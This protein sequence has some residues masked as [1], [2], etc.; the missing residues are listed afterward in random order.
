MEYSTMVDPRVPQRSNQDLSARL[1]RLPVVSSHI[2]WALVLAANLMI[3]YY[4]NAIFAY[5]TPAIKNH[6]D[7]SLGQIGFVNSAFF[8]GM[9]VGA[10]IGG[11][12]ADQLGR[13]PVLMWAT[14]IYSLGAIGTALSQNFEVMLITRVITGIGVQAATSVLLVYVA[15]MFPGR[16]R[17]RFLSVV[18]GGLMF[19]A[20]GAA[21]LAM[22]VLPHGGPNAWR[23]LFMA[24]GVGILIVP[25]IYF[26]LPESVRWYVSVGQ[27]EKAR[28][29]VEKLEAKALRKGPLSEPKPV[30]D[31]SSE[32]PSL[33][34]LITDKSILRVVSIISI[35]FFGAT[36]GYYLFANWALYSLV[37]GLHYSEEK[38]YGIQ[39]IWNVVY[40]VTPFV[41]FFIM[42]LFERKNLMFITAVISA[43][44]LVFLGTSPD[45]WMVIVSGGAAAI[46]TGI[47]I[48]VYYTYIPEAIPL[49]FRGL[50]TGVILSAGRTGGAVSGVLGAALFSQGGI[51][52]V[53]IAAAASYV[54]FSVIVLL[55]GPRTTK[56][57]LEEISAVE[58]TAS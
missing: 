10:L 15:E 40:C 5:S 51:E 49:K 17:G 34:D 33:R 58:A 11:R 37:E 31:Q 14:A 44:T 28:A 36:L 1:D 52:G 2:I 56:R 26:L 38:A 30:P 8:V 25:L 55:L 39:M 19:S 23:H 18:S 12:I 50:G 57:S 45:D 13:R 41:T 42:D 7:L 4:D 3:E 20:V 16:S 43:I 27:S 6:T 22:Y 53:M 32:R 9:I 29:I 21:F 46:I 48:N 54:L 24:G 35:G 47:V